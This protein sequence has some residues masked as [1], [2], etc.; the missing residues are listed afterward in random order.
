VV[1][2][3]V[4][5]PTQ[6]CTTHPKLEYTIM[7]T[8]AA[9]KAAAQAEESR[10]EEKRPKMD[11]DE[12]A[13]EFA[14]LTLTKDMMC[15]LGN[16]TVAKYKTMVKEVEE[17][18][19]VEEQLEK[20]TIRYE[21]VKNALFATYAMLPGLLVPKINFQLLE[22]KDENTWKFF[23]A[24]EDTKIKIDNYIKRHA[25]KT[26]NDLTTVVLPLTLR[27]HVQPDEP[28]PPI[29]EVNLRFVKGG[30]GWTFDAMQVQQQQVLANRPLLVLKVNRSKQNLPPVFPQFGDPNMNGWMSVT[31][32]LPVYARFVFE[33]FHDRGEG[34]E[35]RLT[36][37]HGI[38]ENG[39]RVHFRYYAS[40]VTL[41]L[42]RS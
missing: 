38:D 24:D 27:G 30:Q 5:R 20:M 39:D 21:L 22:R 3:T 34:I 4:L 33:L 17:K 25:A 12:V 29:V 7:M 18:K 26:M 2:A 37:L 41:G 23:N 40:I 16:V 1:G 9:A 10:K 42:S 28:Q 36:R 32:T 15:V 14:K 13:A 8:R 11:P 31:E 19:N 6:A 35:P